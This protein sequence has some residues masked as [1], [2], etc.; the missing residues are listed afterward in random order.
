MFITLAALLCIVSDYITC[1]HYLTFFSSPEKLLHITGHFF[2]VLF[3]WIFCFL[4]TLWRC[5]QRSYRANYEKTKDKY[6]VTTE[7]PRY[8]LA[9]ENRKIQ[10]Q[11]KHLAALQSLCWVQTSGAWGRHHRPDRWSSPWHGLLCFQHQR[12]RPLS[13]SASAPSL[14]FLSSQVFTVSSEPKQK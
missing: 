12:T 14:S 6:T 3:L 8:Q 2:F 4:T 5:E 13:V 11:V 1:L 7:D 10:S 9:R